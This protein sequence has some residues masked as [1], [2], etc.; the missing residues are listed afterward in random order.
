MKAKIQDFR[1]KKF[2][3]DEYGEF[4]GLTLKPLNTPK[5]SSHQI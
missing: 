3:Y 4:G 2:V 5:I 1:L